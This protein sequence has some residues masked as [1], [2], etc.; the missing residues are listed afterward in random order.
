M[1]LSH[2]LQAREQRAQRQKELLEQYKL[3]LICFTMNIAGGQKNSPLITEGFL[4]GE[5]LLLAQ[6]PNTVYSE[7]RLLPTGC[8]GY[9]V[10]PEAPETIKA[11][12]TRIEESLPLGRLFDMDVLD[13]Q[14]QKLSRPHPRKCLL[15]NEDARICARSRNHSLETLR[16][17]TQQLL[18]E[19]LD[20]A[21]TRR[22]QTAAIQSLL[23]ELLTTPKPGLVDCR[24]SGSHKDMDVFTFA[25][26][27][28][29]LAPYFLQCA[30]AGTESRGQ[31]ATELLEPLRYLGR[32]AEAAMYEATEGINTHKGAIFSLGLL[33]AAGGRLGSGATPAALCAEAAAIIE[34][35]VERELA[36]LTPSTART[37]GEALFVHHRIGGIRAQAEAGFPTVLQV[38]LPILTEGLKQGL[39]LHRSGAAALL[40]MLS[41]EADTSLISRSSP[42]RYEALRLELTQLL[43]AHPYPNTAQLEALDTAFI[44]ESLSPGGSADLLSLCHFLHSLPSPVDS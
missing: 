32:N 1:E 10:I 2:L 28:A 21:W 9:Y 11:R 30:Q 40:H 3:P 13:L 24:N 27:T 25:R 19:A 38:G 6:F 18:Q 5:K 34:G 39:S 7:K 22:I 42:Q 29:A 44:Q 35:I 14:G 4:L 43:T 33:C 37:K 8:E 26:S 41:S 23:Y 16:Q 17:R 36:P 31:G 15:C 12:C 20:Q